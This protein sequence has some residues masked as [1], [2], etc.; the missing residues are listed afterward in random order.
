MHKILLT[1]NG[2]ALSPPTV[3]KSQLMSNRYRDDNE[4]LC[5]L[6]IPDAKK[7]F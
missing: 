7:C 2:A 3:F 6:I 4:V 1:W 5:Y